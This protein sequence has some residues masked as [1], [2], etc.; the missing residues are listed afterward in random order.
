MMSSSY[1]KGKW[2]EKAEEE[3][4]QVTYM[5]NRNTTATCAK[6]VAGE[7]R[8]GTDLCYSRLFSWV[9]ACT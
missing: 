2:S 9:P 4:G 1:E 3:E 5:K 8:A 6:A 7:P